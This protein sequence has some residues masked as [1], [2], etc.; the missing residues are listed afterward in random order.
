[1]VTC[2]LPPEVSGVGAEGQRGYGIFQTCQ[3]PSQ[4]Y[5]RWQTK[6]FLSSSLRSLSSL[7]T[8]SSS[9]SLLLQSQ[10]PQRGLTLP[11][12][13]QSPPVLASPLKNKVISFSPWLTLCHCVSSYHTQ[14]NSRSRA[15]HQSNMS[16][17]SPADGIS[18]GYPRWRRRWK[19][20]SQLTHCCKEQTWWS[21]RRL[22]L[23]TG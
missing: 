19:K 15:S 9:F 23:N 11:H 3:F 8:S 17:A 2:S 14:Q 1:M 10:K 22:S 21:T 7:V 6:L 5:P 16:T 13:S 18:A 4:S 20:Q 12:G